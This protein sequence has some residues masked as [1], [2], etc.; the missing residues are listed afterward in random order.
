M[1]LS[2][3]MWFMENIQLS[4]YL[5]SL[6]SHTTFS[7]S[8]PLIAEDSIM[9]TTNKL[10]NNVDRYVKYRSFTPWEME[11]CIEISTTS[12]LGTMFNT[13]VNLKLNFGLSKSKN[14]F[15]NYSM[16]SISLLVGNNIQMK[17]HAKWLRRFTTP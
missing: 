5:I 15:Q 13:R 12:S 1:C 9:I 6:T 16:G 11:M 8:T 4:K 2:W 14:H 3:C 17:R 7:Y 10:L